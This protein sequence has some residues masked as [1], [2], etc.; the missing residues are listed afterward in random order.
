MNQKRIVSVF[1]VAVA[2]MCTLASRPAVAGLQASASRLVGA[3]KDSIERQIPHLSSLLC[4]TID[5][6]VVG[7]DVIVVGNQAA[8]FVDALSQTRADQ[9]V[10]DLVRLP[11]YSSLL[12]ADYR[13]IC[14]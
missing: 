6:V 4:N 8:E 9:I 11:M 13:G 14:W 1:A 7:S 2:A 10:I 3:N 12:K 5:E